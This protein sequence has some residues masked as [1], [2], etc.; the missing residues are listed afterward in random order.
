[1]EYII[2]YEQEKDYEQV[3]AIL[4][5]TFPSEAESRLV[6][7]LRT[8]GKAIISL[9]A[10]CGEDVVGHIMYSPVSTT[11]PGEAKGIGLAPVAVHPDLQSQGIGSKLIATGLQLCRKLGYDFCVVLGD[12]NYFQRFG[13]EAASR[14]GLEN[15]YGVDEEFMVI[16][17]SDREVFGLVKY[18]LEFA[19]FSV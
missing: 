9:V 12:P 8:N 14:F 11:P 3:R 6:D 10:V 16:R 18:S 4:Q 19:L 2:R 13:F 7:A 17:F 5:M 15:E 1:M